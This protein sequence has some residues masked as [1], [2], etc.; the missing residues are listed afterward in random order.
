MSKLGI[1]FTLGACVNIFRE[2]KSQDFIRAN[3]KVIYSWVKL[4]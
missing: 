1:S 3:A 4:K 2:R